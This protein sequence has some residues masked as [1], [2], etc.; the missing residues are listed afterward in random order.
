MAASFGLVMLSTRFFNRFDPTEI[1]QRKSRCFRLRKQERPNLPEESSLPGIHYRN[2]PAPASRFS[3]VGLLRAELTLMLRGNSTLWLILTSG[4]FI[5]S[6]FTPESFSFRVALPLVWFFQILL[7]SELGSREVR[8]RCNEYIFAMVSPLKRQLT[9]TFTAAFLFLSFLSL[10]VLI[11]LMVSGSLYGIFAL[12]TGAMF[13]A[14]FAIASGIITGG[15]KL[16]QVIFTMM[17]YGVLNGI[18]WVDFTGTI[19]GSQKAGLAN[20][21]FFATVLLIILAFAGRK[22]SAH[23]AI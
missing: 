23:N 4:M 19:P 10:P 2:L 1:K 22:R 11:R 3:F 14:A 20:Y 5:A 9:A 16:F 13:I 15:A 8:W 7:L 12:L 6:I 17:V 21:F 18:P